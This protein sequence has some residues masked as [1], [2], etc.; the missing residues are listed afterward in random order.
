MCLKYEGGGIYFHTLATKILNK[1]IMWIHT[2]KSLFPNKSAT[3][4]CLVHKLNV[5]DKRAP[6]SSLKYSVHYA[7]RHVCVCVCVCTCMWVLKNDLTDAKQLEQTSLSAP[8]EIQYLWQSSCL[9]SL[10]NTISQS[11]EEKYFGDKLYDCPQTKCVPCTQNES[12]S[13]LHTLWKWMW[14]SILFCVLFHTF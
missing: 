12:S 2:S 3:G 10:A 1:K 6:I 13:T 11:R 9:W 8:T 7:N 14:Y 4:N 5:S